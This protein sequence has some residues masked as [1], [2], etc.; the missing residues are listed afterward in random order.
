MYPLS[1]GL[2]FYRSSSA[3]NT[4]FRARAHFFSSPYSLLRHSLLPP[5]SGDI[6][7]KPPSFPP[8]DLLP[9]R[10]RRLPS[11]SL[12]SLL[13]PPISFIHLPHVFSDLSLFLRTDELPLI[14]TTQ[15][16]NFTL[17]CIF[18]CCFFPCL[19]A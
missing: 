5:F 9:R 10:R 2:A 14:P 16:P 12:F 8:D 4:S 3:I 6:A 7:G 1:Q 11:G 19:V 17:L 13:A 15:I 18:F